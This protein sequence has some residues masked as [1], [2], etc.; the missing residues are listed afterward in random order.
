MKVEA[1]TRDKIKAFV[2]YC[3]KHRNEVDDSFLYDKDLENFTPNS[4]NPTYI[5]TNQRD[6]IVATASL[7]MNDYYRRGKQG[8]FRI[9]HSEIDDVTYYKNLF[10]KLLEDISDL[11]NLFIYVPTNNIHLM[12]AMP[13]LKFHK[14]RYAFL[15]I[16]D[17]LPIVESNLP[18][19]YH[20]ETHK[21]GKDEQIWCDIRNRAFAELKGSQTPITEEMV[22]K[23]HSQD[24]FITGGMRILYHHDRPVGLVRGSRDEYE[25]APIMNIGPLALITEYQGRGLG[26][27]LIIEALRI[28]KENNYHRTVLSVNGENERAKALY[29][30]EG[31]KEVESVVCYQYYIKK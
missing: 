6:R 31:F 10:Q 2:M 1:L 18:P 29:L 3:R 4:E 22:V 19:H 5:T 25:G 23:L 9:F 13:Q 20:F 28:A 17:V 11:D 27:E 7:I 12:N 24:D 14:E 15:L 30:K 16:R 8:R 21:L 26:R